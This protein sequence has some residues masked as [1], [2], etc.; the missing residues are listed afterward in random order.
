MEKKINKILERLESGE[1]SLSLAI[2]K[3]DVIALK[4]FASSP[5]Q[6]RVIEIRN[7]L[8]STIP[9]RENG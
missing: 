6:K 5:R 3:L 8:Y 2:L 1:I 9:H 4:C 7:K